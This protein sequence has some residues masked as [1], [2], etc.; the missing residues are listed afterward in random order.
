[1]T[2]ITAAADALI[3]AR[4]EGRVMDTLP[5]GLPVDLAE[6]YKVQDAII[7]RMGEPL[8]G[9]KVAFTNAAGQKRMGTDAPGAGPIFASYVQP[10]PATVK[11]PD[12]GLR[13]SECEFAF[14]LA[15]DLPA[16]RGAYADADIAAVIGTVHPAIEVVNRRLSGAVP[17]GAVAIIV[18]HGG[19]GAFAYGPGTKDWR[20][21]DFA[22]HAVRQIIN[23]AEKA[24]GS[25][26]AVM[27]GNPVASVTWLANHLKGRGRTLRAGDWISSGSAVEML[28]VPLGGT[29]QADFG[30]LGSVEV[31]FPA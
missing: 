1:M 23:G 2:D 18:D 28:P 27:D 24:V 12:P 14:R 26:K 6:A 19:N 10:G 11:M 5:G 29:V 4:R 31:R 15:A 22:T 16:K 9:W 30:S 17:M 21:I 25:G 3:R 7:E 20:G 13:I 8:A